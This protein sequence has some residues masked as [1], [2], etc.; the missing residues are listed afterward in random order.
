MR[1]TLLVGVTLMLVGTLFITCSGKKDSTGVATQEDRDLVVAVTTEPKYYNNMAQGST[2]PYE[3]VVYSQV[4]DPLFA[5]DWDKGGEIV[6]ILAE[7]HEM[8]A[9]GKQIK[10]KLRDNVYFHDGTKLTSEDVKFTYDT[11]STRP[12]GIALLIN[13]DH[14]EIID[15]LNFIIHMTDPFGPILNSLCSR[16][17]YISSKAYWEKVGG[18]DGYNAH[19]IGTGPY[20]FVSA[21]SGDSIVFERNENYFRGRPAF[22]KITVKIVPDVNTAVVSVETGDADA[23]MQIPI[24]SL[25]N[26]NNPDVAWDV[27]SDQACGLFGF[28]FLPDRWVAKDLNFRKAVQYAI[29]KDAINEG[30]FYGRTVTID[31][32]GAPT[33]TARPPAGTYHTYTYDPVKAKEFLNASDYKGQEFRVVTWAGQSVEKVCQ[34]IQANL[35]EIG[36][37]MRVIAV[38]TP[39]YWDILRNTGDHDGYMHPSGASTWDMDGL[40]YYLYGMYSMKELQ[41]PYGKELN[42]YILEARASPDIQKRIEIYTKMCNILNDE[43]VQINTH[44]DLNTVLYRKWL[45]GVKADYMQPVY[46]F[47]DWS[48]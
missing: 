14:I 34:I 38:D 6:N 37:N 36:I 18:F 12:L 33:Y 31:I 41:F 10:V 16:L 43:V 21:L 7:S 5:K 13:Y 48:Y 30:V 8:S 45:K 25:I 22:R 20:K 44:M 39:T 46:R 17:G 9:D 40:N 27:A 4:Y 3:N 15:D 28:N 11:L 1:K 29:D 24:D 42:D 2:Q 47:F 32:Y 23:S 35:Q 26:L 19:P